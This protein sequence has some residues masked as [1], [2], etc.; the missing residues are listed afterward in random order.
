MIGGPKNAS[1]PSIP[2]FRNTPTSESKSA[3]VAAPQ[4]LQGALKALANHP[5]LRSAQGE[6]SFDLPCG[7]AVQPPEQAEGAGQSSPEK[8]IEQLGQALAELIST[9]ETTL[10]NPS[11]A[12]GDQEV[13]A[14]N[15]TSASDPEEPLQQVLEIL[16]QLMGSIV[17]FQQGQGAASGN[18]TLTSALGEL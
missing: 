15:G 12:N 11:A 13:S 2:T 17:Q 10:G 4:S 9:L 14:E 6:S 16:K 1:A 7:A 8:M 18:D 5:G 3:D